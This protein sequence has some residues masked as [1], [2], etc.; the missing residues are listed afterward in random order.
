[1]T[2]EFK[3]YINPKDYYDNEMESWTNLWDDNKSLYENI[4]DIL[5]ELVWLPK[6]K[7]FGKLAS[8][9]VLTSVRWSKVLPVLL[10]CGEKGSGKSTISFF[11]NA[12]RGHSY[13]FS[14][15]DTFA[16]IRNELTKMRWLDPFQKDIE[17]EGGILCW[18]NIY[19]STILDNDNLKQMLLC[20]YNRQSS[21]MRIASQKGEN[22]N[23]DVFCPK[24]LSSVEPIYLES[25]L[26]EL[27][28]RLLVIPHKPFEKFSKEDK[29]Y[30]QDRNIAEKLDIDSISWEGI[31]DKYHGFW[32]DNINQPTYAAIRN[33]LTKRGKKDFKIPDNISSQRLTI[34]ID[35]IATGVLL[36]A[37]KNNQDGIDFFSE[38]WDYIDA[39]VFSETSAIKDHL[40]VFIQEEAGGQIE[41]T[42]KLKEAGMSTIPYFIDTRKVQNYLDSLYRDGAIEVKPNPEIRDG[43]MRELGW[44]L[45]R[46]GWKQ[47]D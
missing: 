6:P 31:S 42:K 32:S 41:L 27:H 23:F 38:Y 29:E 4:Y 44:K 34:M 26:T 46:L 15:S 11:A 43:L 45:T 19:S 39:R 40:R 25:K 2:E 28:R 36:K 47:I 37:F 18:D 16:S 3:E 13:T 35:L 17:L 24:I 9:Y 22:I 30:Y 5:T 21:V 7:I 12:I 1:M 20:G 8:L 10:C 33:S 14:P